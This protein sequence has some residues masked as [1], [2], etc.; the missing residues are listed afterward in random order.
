MVGKG[1]HVVVTKID[2]QDVEKL[3]D[4]IADY[5]QQ[6]EVVA[7]TIDGI[8]HWWLM[9]QRMQE[10]KRQVEQA[11]ECLCD[12]GLIEK[13]VMVDGTVLYLSKKNHNKNK[14]Q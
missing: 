14:T 2:E 3:A 6:R 10:R 5:L 9:R 11:V 8:T 4:E 1:I 7:D 12:Q 13:R